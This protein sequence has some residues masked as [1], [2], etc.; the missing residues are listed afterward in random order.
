MKSFLVGVLI[1]VGLLFGFTGCIVHPFVSLYSDISF[2]TG[3]HPQEI[4]EKY[5]ESCITNILGIFATGDASVKKAAEIGGIK[6]VTSV[7][8]R[9]KNILG[10]YSEFCVIVSGY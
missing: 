7:D 10:I 1:L 4:G 9:Y 5:G 2:H 3:D 6:K 8:Y